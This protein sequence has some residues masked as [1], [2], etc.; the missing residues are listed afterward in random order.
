MFKQ[1]DPAFPSDIQHFGCLFL[2]TLYILEKHFGAVWPTPQSVIDTYES[3]E[4]DEDLGQEC[5]VNDQDKLIASIIGPNKA[6]VICG[7]PTTY[8]CGAGEFEIQTWHNEASGFTHFVV[9]DGKGCERANVEWDPILQPDGV[10]GSF[11]VM[12]GVCVGKRIIK[13]L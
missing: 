9:G 6:Q 12:R 8:I 1:T 13:A 7:L 5:F 2:S 10:T 11:T 3:E 4:N